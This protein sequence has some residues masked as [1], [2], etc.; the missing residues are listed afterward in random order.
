[1]DT[2]DEVMRHLFTHTG[3]HLPF[4]VM[5]EQAL[6]A[7]I[8]PVSRLSMAPLAGSCPASRTIRALL[9]ALAGALVLGACA[10][11][12]SVKQA[13]GQGVKRTFRYSGDA[14]FQA[15][16]TVGTRRKLEF[17]EQNRA[18]GVIVFSSG[19]SLTSLGERIAVFITRAS[20]R[21]TAVEIVSKPVGGAVTFPPDWPGILYGDLEHELAVQKLK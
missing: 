11:P 17:V 6:T 13:Q 12:E 16:L 2:S 10:S 18:G 5:R 9:A 20:D 19:A 4:A 1:M 21:S 14:V 15:L 7:S 8:P 3:Y